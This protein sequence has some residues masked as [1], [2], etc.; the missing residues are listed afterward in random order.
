MTTHAKPTLCVFA[1]PP[2]PGEAKTRLAAELGGA[3]AAALASCFLADTWSMAS[4]LDWADAV[5]ATTDAQWGTELVGLERAWLQGPGDL[6]QRMERVLRRALSRGGSAIALGADSPGLP[7][8]LLD[9]ARLALVDH[10]AALGPCD[11]GGFY[12]LA[13][14]Q[15]PEGLLAELP[16][17]APNTFQKTVARLQEKGLSVV[18]ISPWFDVD[19][20]ADLRRLSLLL[21]LG[22]ISAPSTA[23]QLG[24]RVPRQARDCGHHLVD[25]RESRRG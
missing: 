10:D 21:A 17:S 15:C 11:D 14:N 20:P 4:S 6:G 8:R 1:K 9:E 5:L 2:R 19:V 3:R 18:T 22:A 7:P 24:I 12:L 16:W 25:E 13:L 23:M